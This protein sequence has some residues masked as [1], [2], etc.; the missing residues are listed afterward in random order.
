MGNLRDAWAV[1]RG[2]RTV[3]K[4]P[5]AGVTP[6][7]YGSDP[8]SVDDDISLLSANAE[9]YRNWT[10]LEPDRMSV[11]SDMDEM[12]TYVLAAS[13]MEAYVE[14]A[15]QEDFNSGLVVTPESSNPEVSATLRNFFDRIELEDRV[16]GDMWHMA[17][18]GDYFAL[19]MVDEKIGVYDAAPLE[20]RIVWRHEDSRRVLKGFSIGD[21]S[22]NVSD[23]QQEIPKYKPWDIV[24]WRLRNRRIADPYGT[25]FFFNVRLIYKIL[26]LMEE[27]MV[28]YRMN[29]HPDRL[30]FKVFTGNAGPEERRR[31]IRM[32]R[33]EMEKTV[34]LDRSTGQFRAEYRPWTIN[35]NIYWPVGTNDTQSGVEKFPGCFTGDTRVSLL[36]GREEQIKDIKPGDWVYSCEQKT[37]RIKPGKVTK[38]WCARKDA[39]LVRVTVD[40]GES[41]RCTP[42]HKFLLRNGEYREAQDLKPG[43]SLMPLYRKT[44][45]RGEDRRQL[46][47]YELVWDNDLQKW[48]YTHKMVTDE[49]KVS[50]PKGHVRHHIDFDKRNNRPDNLEIMERRAHFEFH[51][52][53]MAERWKIPGYKDA[54]ISYLRRLWQEPGRKEAQADVLRRLWEDPKIAE[55]FK[56][57][58]RRWNLSEGNYQHL[59]RCVEEFNGSPE[60]LEI[61]KRLHAEGKIGLEHD[62]VQEKIWTPENREAQAERMAEYNCSDHHREKMR[63]LHAGGRSGFSNPEILKKAKANPDFEKKRKAGSKRYLCTRWHVNRGVFKDDCEFCQEDLRSGVSHILNGAGKAATEGIRKIGKNHGF[64]SKITQE[65]CHNHKVVSVER[66]A[67]REDVYDI[68][69]DGFHNFALSPGFGGVLVSN[70][71]NAGDIFDVEYMRDLFFSGVRV[72][73][74]YMG[75]EDS[76]GYRGTDT[77]SAQSI[78]FARGVKRMQRYYLKGLTRLCKIHLATQGIDAR[79]PESSFTLKMTPPS[80][81]DEAHRAELFAKRY[82]ALNFMIDI[83]SKMASELDINKKFWSEYVLGEFGGFDD[84]LLSKL[85]TPDMEAE[86]DASFVPDDHALTFERAKERQKI[87]EMVG[88]DKKLSEAAATLRQAESTS[89]VKSFSAADKSPLPKDGKFQVDESLYEEAKEESAKHRERLDSEYRRRMQERQ[90]KLRSI[91]EDWKDA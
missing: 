26:K 7:R 63:Q 15:V 10:H 72:P 21:A 76:Q 82:E 8:A 53:N 5:Q 70:S 31:Q 85:T 13:A 57:N 36:D 4:D 9:F 51:A 2:L 65:K 39:E 22:E 46:D 86:P 91:A 6:V 87:Q 80:Y 73:K 32:W 19:V 59:L 27:Q 16:L 77:L 78:K 45:V 56:D 61:V 29:M 38:A 41:V 90:E 60:H 88:N 48:R 75:F 81:L 50:V 35:Q 67:E 69:V 14:D 11:Y 42:D 89:Y 33:R 68:T 52:M 66:L 84:E 23:S 37:G 25:P 1:L 40:N 83:G 71:A 28:I 54:F 30:I 43:D 44:S 62:W 17:K 18:Y 58:Q 12:F 64:G 3:T 34:S 47:G 20:P 49:L 74:G 55:I 24:H 79:R